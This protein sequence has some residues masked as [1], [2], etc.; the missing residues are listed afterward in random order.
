MCTYIY[1]PF[2]INDFLFSF[3]E[4]IVNLKCHKNFADIL[5]KP[6]IIWRDFMYFC[7]PEEF[8]L[9]F[10]KLV[11]NVRMVH[12]GKAVTNASEK[13]KTVQFFFMW[14]WSQTK[15]PL[16]LPWSPL[17]SLDFHQK[18]ENVKWNANFLFNQWFLCMMQL[19]S[20]RNCLLIKLKDYASVHFKGQTIHYEDFDHNKCLWPWS[21]WRVFLRKW[22]NPF[23]LIWLISIFE[24]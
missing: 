20:F 12:I 4:K 21:H 24:F 14:F 17:S 1:R 2:N 15:L 18:V 22:F 23:L 6:Q 10:R 3:S 16:L 8:E 19:F 13:I 9:F 5:S 11:K 7:N